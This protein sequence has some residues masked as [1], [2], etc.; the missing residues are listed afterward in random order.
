MRS[1][2]LLTMQWQ[3]NSN[4]DIFLACTDENTL[5][6]IVDEIK[7]ASNCKVLQTDFGYVFS[8]CGGKQVK[9]GWNTVQQLCKQGWEPFG[10]FQIGNSGSVSLRRVSE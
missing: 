3:S 6:W 10:D 1:W 7:K 9:I 5:N 2:D 4:P 8:R